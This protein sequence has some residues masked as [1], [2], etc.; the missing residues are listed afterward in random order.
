GGGLQVPLLRERLSFAHRNR[1]LPESGLRR[2]AGAAGG[3]G[4]LAI[5]VGF[6]G[7]KVSAN[8]ATTLTSNRQ[9]ANATDDAAHVRDTD[10][11]PL[12]GPLSQQCDTGRFAAPLSIG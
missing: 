8:S 10:S 6:G 4:N 9:T 7:G 3:S 12:V 2:G 1:Q 5:S 11:L